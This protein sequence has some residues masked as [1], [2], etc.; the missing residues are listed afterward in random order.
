MNNLII[1]G[2]GFDLAHGL[3]TI[4]SS[5]M[6]YLVN[7][8]CKDRS[9]FSDLFMLPDSIDCHKAL[10]QNLQIQWL[11]KSNRIDEPI[12]GIKLLLVKAILYDISLNNWSDIECL[13]FQILKN[14]DN[15]PYIYYNSI[16]KLN[17]DFA[18]LK[19]HLQNY[20]TTQEKIGDSMQ[21]YE[22]LFKFLCVDNSLLLNF[23]YTN[24]VERLYKTETS[25]SKTV[26]IH[27]KLNS[28]NNPIIF[29]FAADNDDMENLIDKDD[30]EYLRNIKRHEYK[31]TNNEKHLKKYLD[32]TENIS[33]FIIGHSCAISDKQILEQILNHPNIHSV[34]ILY[35]NNYE[36]YYQ[37]QVNIFRIIK[38]NNSFEKLVS[39]QDC[40]KMPQ[41]SETEKKHTYLEE[42]LDK[43]NLEILDM[44]IGFVSS[45]M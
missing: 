7:E 38:N 22:E 3:K 15:D 19:S 18:V 40:C 24:T 2:N 17:G 36:S 4:Y 1:I 32:Q 30:N 42:F 14:L 11:N 39:F 13:Y 8:H 45:Y 25:L 43:L 26:Y 28:L 9:Q 27:G 10:I 34:Y 33:I 41:C 35:H 23:N 20:L 5:F 21:S 31:R 6:E 16:K 12:L 37:T 44:N 29:G